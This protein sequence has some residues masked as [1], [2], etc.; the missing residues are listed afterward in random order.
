MAD[1]DIVAALLDG[2]VRFQT[3]HL[4]LGVAE[5]FCRLDVSSYLDLAGTAGTDLHITCAG[6]YLQMH[7]PGRLQSALKRSF[8]RRGRGYRLQP[9]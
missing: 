2:R 6:R 9:D 1:T 5:P 4:L 3:F 7:R 8:R